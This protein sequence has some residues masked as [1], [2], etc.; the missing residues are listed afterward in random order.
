MGAYQ[1]CVRTLGAQCAVVIAVGFI[2][3]IVFGSW[4]AAILTQVVLAL[5]EA[6]GYVIEAMLYRRRVGG[7]SRW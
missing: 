7:A 5:S 6:A 1:L 3:G 2:A 4:Q